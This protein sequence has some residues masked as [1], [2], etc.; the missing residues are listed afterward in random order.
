MAFKLYEKTTT[1]SKHICDFKNCENGQYYNYKD[2]DYCFEHFQELINETTKKCQHDI[3]EIGTWNSYFIIK[4][5][6]RVCGY[7]IR[8]DM[9]SKKLILKVM[10]FLDKE[11]SR[12]N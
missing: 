2:K 11:N 6:H 12:C 4:C 1:I 7:K 3:L 5:S 9:S 8:Y 10:N